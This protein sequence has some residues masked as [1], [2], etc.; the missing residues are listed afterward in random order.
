MTGRT[1]LLGIIG[2]PLTHSVSPEMQNAALAAM[3][4]DL[5]YVPFPVQEG[6]LREA[7]SGLK[8][9]GVRG[10]N[11]T[12]PFKEAVLSLADTLSETVR[13]V[14][15]ANTLTFE[16]DGRILAENTDTGAFRQAVLQTVGP[17][18]KGRKAVILGAGGAAR[19]VL[20]A[21]S[22]MGLQE[23]SLF[24]RRR[25]RAEKV[26]SEFQPH[27]HG[28]YCE[29]FDLERGE[30]LCDEIS[31]ADLLVQAT[32]VGMW[33]DA[34]ACPILDFTC[35]HDGLSVFDLVYN[36]EDTRLI[37]EAK[38]RGLSASG[39]LLMLVFQGALSLSIWT[40]CNPPLETML[41]A[42]RE[43]VNRG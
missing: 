1:R 31:K 19:A 5:S 9:L 33:P 41:D 32:S 42:A 7:V 3:G 35:L 38:A 43:A 40:G 15:A 27:L 37:K 30:A 22:L 21:L 4:L 36:P 20:C 18:W 29:A 14:G 39:G 16:S 6:C 2:S 8:A 25:D 24:N 28:V 11:V 12:L 10:V 26:L 13:K 34:D 17:Y 23:I